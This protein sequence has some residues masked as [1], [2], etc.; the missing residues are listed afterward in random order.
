MNSGPEEEGMRPVDIEAGV[1]FGQQERVQA[2]PWTLAM[3]SRACSYAEKPY[4]SLDTRT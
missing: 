4:L 1:N 2:D 3:G